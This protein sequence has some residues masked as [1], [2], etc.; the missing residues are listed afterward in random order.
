MSA[1]AEA[2]QPTRRPAN[3]MTLFPPEV[4]TNIFRH[5]DIESLL[6]VAEA[7]PELKRFAFTPT[8][9]Q[10]VT[11]AQETDERTVRQYQQT[12][13]QELDVSNQ[14]REVPL[15]VHAHELH[16]TNCLALPSEGAEQ[17][18]LPFYAYSKDVSLELQ[19]T[20][21]AEHWNYIERLNL[22]QEANTKFPPIAPSGDLDPMRQFFETSVS[23]LTELNLTA[24][25]FAVD[26][27]ACDVVA[28]ALPKLR[29]LALTPCGANRDGSLESLA[30]GCA[31]LEIL[32][33]RASAC[34]CL[35]SSCAACQ[36]P[37]RFTRRGFASLHRTTRLRRLSID[38]TAKIASLAFL[39]DC[40][41][42][43][44]RLSLDSA[45]DKDLAKCPT[46]LCLLLS[47]NPQLSSLT[48]VTRKVTLSSRFAVDLSGNAE[49]GTLVRAHCGASPVRCGEGILCRLGSQTTK[50]SI[51]SRAFHE[52]VQ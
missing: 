7:A 23:R 42:E 39:V 19:A 16:F 36:L 3:P 40:R 2:S 22:A 32:D 31:S 49:L 48:L 5:L 11:V 29:A 41:V 20:A 50:A 35:A 10:R 34:P 8:V 28:S 44:L 26:C 43:E 6:S 14:I 38:E 47:A 24:F 13:R 52:H 45:E 21:Y 9:L 37:L 17:T 33:V 18:T 46:Q 30:D 12:T 4:W 15:T 25:H 51:G 1:S 27:N